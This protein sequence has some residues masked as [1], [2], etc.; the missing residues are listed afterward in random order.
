MRRP[1]CSVIWKSRFSC[2]VGGEQASQGQ[3]GQLLHWGQTSQC[4]ATKNFNV[5][6][7]V[8]D[9]PQQK[10]ELHSSLATL[11]D[12]VFKSKSAFPVRSQCSLESE[13]FPVH[14]PAPQ[15]SLSV[16]GVGQ[17]KGPWTQVSKAMPVSEH[18]WIVHHKMRKHKDGSVILSTKQ[19]LYIL[20]VAVLFFLDMLVTTD[21]IF[22]GFCLLFISSCAK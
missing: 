20:Q 3:C 21:N 22:A 11:W 12:P 5:Q 13:L 18:I 4:L 15:G 1:T 2:P 14:S 6:N 10:E 9:E 17:G 8:L 19:L 7:F 16:G